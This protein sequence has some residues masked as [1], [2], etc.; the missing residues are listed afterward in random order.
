MPSEEL[1]VSEG[2]VAA[3]P[4]GG[5]H[6]FHAYVQISGMQWSLTGPDILFH[7]CLEGKTLCFGNFS[8]FLCAC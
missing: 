7:F 4:L 1:R 5:E 2:L 8:W 3:Q 6:Y